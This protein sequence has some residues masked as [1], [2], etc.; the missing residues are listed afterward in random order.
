MVEESLNDL[1]PEVPYH[2]PESDVKWQKLIECVLTGKSK[3]YLSK[4]YAK[5]QIKNS[6]L[7]KWISS[8]ALTKRNS[9]AK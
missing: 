6:V 7:K 5:E 9:Q 2:P 3:Q 1:L 4:A 8:S